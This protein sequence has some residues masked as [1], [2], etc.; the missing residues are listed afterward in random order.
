MKGKQQSAKDAQKTKLKGSTF[1]DF[2]QLK[3]G[4]NYE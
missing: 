2:W 1:S 3:E 4:T